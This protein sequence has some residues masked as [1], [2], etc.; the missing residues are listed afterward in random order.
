MYKICPSCRTKNP[1]N[2]MLC[3]NC[4]ADIS[5][6]SID[7]D[8]YT[9]DTTE[10]LTDNKIETQNQ[11]FNI[12]QEKIKLELVLVENKEL[13]IEIVNNGII[14]RYHLGK[15]IFQKLPNPKLISREHANIFFKNN[16][17]YIRDLNSTNGTYLL[18]KNQSKGDNVNEIKLEPYKDYEISKGMILNIAKLINFYIE[19]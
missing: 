5:S 9:I 19:I 12:N 4:M 1:I 18:S 13:K 8:I 14:G 7:K 15:E 6:V 11:N 16:K 2:E 17:W 3:I 10:N